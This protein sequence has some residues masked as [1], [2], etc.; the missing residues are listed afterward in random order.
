MR[1][2]PPFYLIGDPALVEAR[3]RARGIVPDIAVVTPQEAGAAFSRAL[4][5]VPLQA[6]FGDTPGRPD[7]ANATGVVEIGRAHV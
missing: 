4:P 7:P 2:I 5:V 1:G 6:A 3:A